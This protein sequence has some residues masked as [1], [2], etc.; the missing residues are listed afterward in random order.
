MRRAG[1]APITGLPVPGE[2]VGL[3]LGELAA[4]R[5]RRTSP[6]SAVGQRATPYIAPTGDR[7]RARGRWAAHD[8][9][10]RTQ[11]LT[12][13]AVVGRTAA[14]ASYLR[15]PAAIPEGSAYESSSDKE[16]EPAADAAE[17]AA[18]DAA[19]AHGGGAA[20]VAGREEADEVRSASRATSPGPWRPTPARERRR[21]GCERN[22]ALE[23][24]R[25]RR[26][27]NEIDDN[28]RD[29]LVLN[30][31]AGA[32]LGGTQGAPGASSRLRQPPRRRRRRRC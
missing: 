32:A 11:H 8:A 20:G 2:A 27:L 12:R 6:R 15:L 1:A 18:A 19:E 24:R 26:A 4:H 28:W 9:L 17:V 22:A 23:R 14:R 30:Q 16:N 21:R 10:Y 31:K 13:A 25:R 3:A 5:D 7:P 29:D